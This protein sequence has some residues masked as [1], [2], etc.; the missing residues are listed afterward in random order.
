MA[1]DDHHHIAGV[2]DEGP[3]ASLAVTNLLGLPFGAGQLSVG[4]QQDG[5]QGGDPGAGGRGPASA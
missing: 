2:L 3:E 4:E 1:I 5:Q